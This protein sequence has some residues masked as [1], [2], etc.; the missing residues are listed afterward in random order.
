MGRARK[1]TDIEYQTRF[2]FE[3]GPGIAWELGIPLEDGMTE[4]REIQTWMPEKAK[5]RCY[6]CGEGVVAVER[7]DD[8][9]RRFCLRCGVGQPEEEVRK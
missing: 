6:R 8:G 3:E 7:G 2:D 5:T 9:L 1:L 4:P